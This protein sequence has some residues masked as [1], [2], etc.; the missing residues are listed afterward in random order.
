M[1]APSGR[2]PPKALATVITS[3]VTPQ[4]WQAN[5]RPERPIPP[6]T[7]SHMS[8]A[9][10]SV[11]SSR[12]PGR[13][14]SDGIRTPP[15]PWTGSTITAAV[16]SPTASAAASRSSKGAKRT[17]SSSGSKGLRHSCFQVTESAPKVRPWND[18]SKATKPGRPVYLRA[19]FRAPSVA[20]VPVL[21]RKAVSRPPGVTD[22]SRRA[23]STCGGRV[24]RPYTST[25]AKRPACRRTASTTA[26]WQCP[27]LETAIPEIMSNRMRPSA[28]LRR[29]PAAS[30][31]TVSLTPG[32]VW[33]RYSTKSAR[34]RSASSSVIAGRL[35]SCPAT[36]S[37]SSRR[38]SASALP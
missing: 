23:I 37:P 33:H 5:H 10:R 16:S 25:W 32:T 19:S 20:S 31:I 38:Q 11:H 12:R 21:V 29:H 26:G 7:S 1:K 13:K 36:V 30:T 4:F 15:S 27:T 28:V 3:G 17:G 34:Q 6:C 2:P 8:K 18:R 9:P 22:A 24:N 35:S 14:P